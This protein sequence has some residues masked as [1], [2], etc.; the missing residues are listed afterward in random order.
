MPPAPPTLR[1]AEVTLAA[2]APPRREAEIGAMLP[3]GV[4]ILGIRRGHQNELVDPDA[5]LKSGDAMLLLG[6]P[7]AVDQ[8]VAALG[9]EE[10]GRLAKDRE[11]LDVVRVI[12]SK[13]A[14]AYPVGSA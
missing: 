6:P 5:L 1:Y 11:E 4:E 8:A 10:T 14:S 9:V 3:P 13:A 12:I 2:G 7:V